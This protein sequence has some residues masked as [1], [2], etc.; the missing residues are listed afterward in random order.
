[1]N[2]EAGQATHASPSKGS[3]TTQLIPPAVGVAT[4]L[5]GVACAVFTDAVTPGN[6]IL[7]QGLGLFVYVCLRA[8]LK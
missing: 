6:C 2:T 4:S 5:F 8:L 3:N 7:A 1:M